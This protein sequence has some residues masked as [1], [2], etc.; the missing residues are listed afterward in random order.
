LLSGLKFGS[1]LR[2]N[3]FIDV[4]KWFNA[5]SEQVKSMARDIGSRQ[6]PQIIGN[7]SFEIGIV[8]KDVLSSI[9]LTN[10]KQVFRSSRFIQDIDILNDD[11][12]LTRMVDREIANV[13]AARQS[14]W[15]FAGEN[16]V[17]DAYSIRGRY[18]LANN[19]IV[20][21]VSVF[22]NQKERV[23]HFDVTGTTDKRDDLAKK[24]VDITL[25][26]MNQLAKGNL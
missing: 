24:I 6:D 18:E 3:K 4:T 19:R 10:K 1:G 5:A 20:A 14:P 8:D 17:D 23:H 12:D 15:V 13:A 2:D 7:A 25:T 9:Q 21:R 26:F 11:L 16:P 22:R